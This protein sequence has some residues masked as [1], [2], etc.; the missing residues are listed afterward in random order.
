MITIYQIQLTDEQIETVNRNGHNSVPAQRARMNVMFGAKNFIHSD[1]QYYMPTMS[2]DTDDLEEA[3]ELTNLWNNKDRVTRFGPRQ[4]SSSVGDI[5]RKGAQFYMV[6]SFGF[7]P[8]YFF[9]DEID[10][11]A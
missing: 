11:V 10:E 5:F 1:F 3:F 9:N 2:V 4:S 8:I 7:T 6:D